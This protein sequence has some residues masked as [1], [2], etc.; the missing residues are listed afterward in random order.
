VLI[1]R[2]F[3]F[4][5]LVVLLALAAPAAASRGGDLRVDG[6]RQP[7][8]RLS[9]LEGDVS[10]GP[11]DAPGERQAGA[12]NTPLTTGDRLRVGNGGRA[13]LQVRG[14]V[15][16]L[17][18]GTELSIPAAAR[19]S[20]LL[21]VA[22]GTVTIR[23]F[24]VRGANDLAF[25]TPNASV[26]L[27]LPGVYRIDVSDAGDTAIR[28]ARGRARVATADGGTRLGWGERMRVFGLARPEYDL[29]VLG[30]WD[31]WDRWVE[32]RSARFR[33]FRSA[34]HVHPD[35]CGVDDL[36]AWGDWE[37]T[38]ERGWVWFPRVSGTDWMPYRSGRWIWREPWGWTW[39]SDEPWGW[40]PYHHGRWT[41]V[42]SR[43]AWL[44]DGPTGPAPSWLPAVVAFVGGGPGAD[45]APGPDGYVG[46]FPLGPGEPLQPW[47]GRAEG[48]DGG[49]SYRYEHRDRALY[50]PRSAFTSSRS[51]ASDL[52]RHPDLLRTLRNAPLV[53]GPLPVFPTSDASRSSR[54]SP[55]NASAG[56]RPALPVRRTKLPA[57]VEG[58][59]PSPAPTPARS[60]SSAPSRNPRPSPRTPD[61][62]PASAPPWP[63]D[64]PRLEPR[65]RVG[66]GAPAEPRATPSSA[67]PWAPAPPA[68]PERPAPRP[69]PQ[70]GPRR[71]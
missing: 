63:D 66:T 21:S 10:L 15:L 56:P 42:R 54:E 8:T 69:T 62:P 60:L 7:V 49:A 11:G 26:A 18:S 3:A 65:P 2:L 35:V 38:D 5:P 30:Q 20:R 31:A 33:N 71:M 12:V 24:G 6:L 37:S 47:Q 53:Q 40:A 64:G 70:T 28:V 44:P 19:G 32:R 48:P 29:V 41:I 14:A 43:W 55:A 13:E 58:A 45:G 59:A 57:P 22:S 50:V 9:W 68:G 17:S 27:E 4:A 25:E 46:W 23:V 39:L 67:P 16:F 34:A 36:D 1:R 51:G 52:V 61:A